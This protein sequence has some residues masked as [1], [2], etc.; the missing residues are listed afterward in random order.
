MAT[1]GSTKSSTTAKTEFIVEGGRARAFTQRGS[2]WSDKYPRL[3]EAAAALPVTSAIIDGEVIVMNE[4][5]LSDFGKLRSSIRLHLHLNGWDLR[6]APPIERRA[7]LKRLCGDA[8]DAIQF[9]A[10]VTGAALAYSC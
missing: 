4:A 5:G 1:A 3:V 8:S 2:D 6:F 10:H 7:E 9:S